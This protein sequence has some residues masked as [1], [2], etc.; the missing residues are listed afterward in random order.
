[1]VF[2]APKDLECFLIYFNL[3][4]N[5]SNSYLKLFVSK[6]NYSR[7]VDYLMVEKYYFLITHLIKSYL[8]LILRR[9]LGCVY[10]VRNV[11]N[12]FISYQIVLL[13]YQ[14]QF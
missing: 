2:T 11:I 6:S 10:M 13:L 12:F 9:C 5:S 4:S 8:L 7:H 3:D 14:H 1:M